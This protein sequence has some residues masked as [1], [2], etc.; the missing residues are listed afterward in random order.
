ML[1]PWTRYGELVLE[2]HQTTGRVV[3]RGSCL[4]EIIM[5]IDHFE[6][7]SARIGAIRSSVRNTLDG[8]SSRWRKGRF[9]RT[10]LTVEIDD[11]FVFY[12]V[13]S[14]AA[15]NIPMDELTHMATLWMG[16]SLGIDPVLMSLRCFMQ[17]DGSSA[18]I[19]GIPSEIIQ[20]VT[21]ETNIAGY[22]IHRLEPRF[23]AFWNKFHAK[24]V[25]ANAIVLRCRGSSLILGWLK[26][27]KWKALNSEYLSVMN[28]AHLRNRCQAFCNRY[29]VPNQK[30]LPILF[31]VETDEISPEELGNWR[32][33]GTKFKVDLPSN[34]LGQLV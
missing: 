13:I 32:Y 22:R 34:Y 33:I 26:D 6:D 14:V 18:V 29:C 27:G 5:P 20:A 31:D 7:P 21:E 16:D 17:G 24:Q 11:T 28:W 19:C 25:D 9:G 15:R 12:D 23:S 1:L 8:V 3:C 10:A 30:N 4:H 2:P